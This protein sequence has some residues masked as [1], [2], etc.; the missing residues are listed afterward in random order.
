MAAATAAA[1]SDATD[2]PVLSLINKRIRALRKKQ[3]RITQMEEAVSQGK[4]INKEQEETLK[5]KPSV[6]AAIDELE[7]LRQ[8]LSAA[9]ADETQLALERHTTTQNPPTLEKRAD[10]DVIGDL[11]NLLYFGTMF[12]VKPQSEYTS[13]MLTRTHERGCCLTY[14]Y[15]TDDDAADLLGE[16]DL[17][18]ISALGGLLVSRPVDSSLSH[19]D[20]LRRCVE[21]AKLWLANSAQPIEPDSSVTYAGLREKLTKIMGSDYFTTTPEMRAPVDVAAAAA[22]FGLGVNV[23]VQ[24]EDELQYQHKEEHTEDVQ[25]NETYDDQYCPVEE[26]HKVLFVSSD[27]YSYP[28]FAYWQHVTLSVMQGELKFEN[29]AEISAETETETETGKYEAEGAQSYEGGQFVPRKSYQSQ[30]GGRGGGGDRR[31]YSNGRRGRGNGRGG[32]GYQNGRTQYYDQPGFYPRNYH[33]NR[34]RGGRGG[35]GGGNS[36]THHG[37]AGHAGNGPIES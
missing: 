10:D 22:N 9:V 4:P 26:N 6:L 23:P 1:A 5:S 32:G 33:N 11:L 37:S 18:S 12:D 7:K 24:G 2:G 14:D 3:N 8:P 30:R 13:T 15:V 28:L 34:G 27:V 31:G 35:A 25:G 19:K 16:R 17:D 20:A 21:R 36:Y 29:A